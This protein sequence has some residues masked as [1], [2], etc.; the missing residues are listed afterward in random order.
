MFANFF[1]GNG[2]YK[3]YDIAKMIEDCKQGRM[4]NGEGLYILF[5]RSVMKKIYLKIKYDADIYNQV[6]VEDVKDLCHD[7]FFKVLSNINR[8]KDPRAFKKCLD[9]TAS[10]IAINYIKEK[11]RHNTVLLTELMSPLGKDDGEDNLEL[12]FA[13][14]EPDFRQ[15]LIKE[16]EEALLRRYIERLP[17]QVQM[18]IHLRYR[19]DEKDK[20]CNSIVN[21]Y[22]KNKSG[23]RS[24]D[25][26]GRIM[27]VS[28][29]KAILLVTKGQE[30]LSKMF[31]KI[32]PFR[33][34]I[35]D[36]KGAEY[37]MLEISQVVNQV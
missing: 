36:E 18:A 6:S 14:D 33:E 29:G 25:E 20:F 26:I 10:R 7:S 19:F 34:K 13:S 1:N 23:C 35:E 28:K 21:K 5:V 9:I 27:G 22:H 30:G 3:K 16:E 2:N 11:R 24:Y 37:E 31:N 15:L 4:K 32:D 17:S 8:L 12:Q